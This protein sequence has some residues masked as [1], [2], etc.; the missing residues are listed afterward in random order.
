MMN[1]CSSD[2]KKWRVPLLAYLVRR[3]GGL[4]PHQYLRSARLYFVN[5]KTQP[6][7]SEGPLEVKL[8]GYLAGNSVDPEQAPATFA[9]LA[10]GLDVLRCLEN[11]SGK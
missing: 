7:F 3:W 1:L 2:F 4:H 8:L 5:E 9:T 6:D 10:S 11:S